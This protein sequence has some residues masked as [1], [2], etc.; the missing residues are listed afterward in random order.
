VL[1]Q[2]T[3]FRDSTNDLTEGAILGGPMSLAQDCQSMSSDGKLAGLLL[4]SLNSQQT[5]AVYYFTI[6]PSMFLS[7]HPDY[8]LIHRLERISL[9]QT[10]VVCQFLFH[11]DSMNDSAFD[12]S[13]AIEFWDSTNR[14]D[15]HVCELTQVGMSN[16]GY[17]PGPYSDLESIVAA[18]DRHYLSA[19]SA[20]PRAAKP[21][22]SSQ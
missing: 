21:R 8:V 20:E 18:F 12:P 11:P 16:R 6:F 3:P 15:W 9:Q 13:R 5:R 4:P 1:N 19:L 14:Q 2:L 10:R 7:L 17:V 22:P